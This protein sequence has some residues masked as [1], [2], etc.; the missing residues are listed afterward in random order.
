MTVGQ[1]LGGANLETSFPEIVGE[2]KAGS[3]HLGFRIGR[4]ARLMRKR[5]NARASA[6]GLTRAQWH[7]ISVVRY[8]EGQSQRCIAEILEGGEVT[9]GRLIAQLEKD[10]WLVRRADP[11]DGRALRVF[12]GA[13]AGEAL[14]T[15]D[16]IGIEQEREA[17]AGLSP[18]DIVNFLRCVDVISRNLGQAVV[19]DKSREP[20]SCG[21][22]S[23]SV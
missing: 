4:M 20:G 16:V 7:V 11:C 8:N 13:D 21:P 1:N 6:S 9:A 5:H 15:L 22:S 19:A 14:R 10:N 17:L 18:A 12:L 3:I 2:G 23:D